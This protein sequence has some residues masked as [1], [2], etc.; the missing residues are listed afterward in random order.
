MVFF[1][2][3]QTDNFEGKIITLLT[4]YLY[5]TYHVYY[6]C[7]H[8]VCKLVYIIGHLKTL[9]FCLVF[10]HGTLKNKFGPFLF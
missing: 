6:K 1:K 8:Y 2:D 10:L 5:I 7:R 9:R 4:R 3:F